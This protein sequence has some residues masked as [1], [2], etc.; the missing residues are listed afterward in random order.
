V[1]KVGLLS[2]SHG[3][4]D[5]TRQ[6]V[7]VLLDAGA[8]LLVHL[9]DIESMEVIDALVVPEAPTDRK[10]ETHIVFG[11]VDWGA[12]A[13][14][15]YARSLGVYVHNPVGRLDTGRGELVFLHGDRAGAIRQALSRGVRYICHGH[16]H[17]ARDEVTGPTRLINPGALSRT[18]RKTVA[19]LDTDTDE[20]TFYPVPRC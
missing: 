12:D 18:H 5:I 19:L 9:G 7:R 16:S 3:R 6:A 4:A 8:Q 20:L 11:N 17:L 1:P 15:E 10:V 2:D 14:S 13:L